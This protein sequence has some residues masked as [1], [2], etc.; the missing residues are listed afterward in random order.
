MLEPALNL[1]LLASPLCFLAYWIAYAAK[2]EVSWPRS[3]LKTLATLLPALVGLAI[4]RSGGLQ[5][6]YLGLAFGALGDFALSRRGE[7]A[8]L[9]G[10]AA[11]VLGHLLYAYALWQRSQAMIAADLPGDSG[12]ISALQILA[13]ALL[14]ALMLSTELWLAPR[15]AT[16]RWPVRGYVVVIGAM[17]ATA[18]LLAPNSGHVLLRLGAALF[19]LSDGLL[20][21]RRFVVTAPVWQSRLSLAL[22]PAYWLGQMLIAYGAIVYW[23]YP[24]G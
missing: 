17:A 13:L 12:S 21:L 19:V 16:L 15:T 20:A 14:A 24:K 9:A 6:I 1:A 8:F 3:L 11:F 4:T 22:W 23:I 10:M 18:I 5:L 7:P 2:D